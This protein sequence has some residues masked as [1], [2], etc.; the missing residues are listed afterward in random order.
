MRR[1][2]PGFG[3]AGMARA[4]PFALYI[5]FLVLREP[6]ATW[7]GPSAAAWLYAAQIAV[8]LAAL[9]IYWG[10]YVE[11]RLP[12][13]LWAR[14]RATDIALVLVVGLGVFFA[15]I[16]LDV[17]WLS[18][19]AGA[20]AASPLPGNDLDWLWIGVRIAGAALVVPVMEELFWRSFI[21]RW[22]EA[23]DFLSIDPRNVSLFAILLS[24]LAFGLE[25]SLW[26]AGLLAGLAYAWLYRRGSLWLAIA[27]HGVTNLAL[28]V[29]VVSSGQWQFW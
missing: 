19:N 4:L 29:W 8:V 13:N 24:S 16:N 6:V 2:L 10:D 1:S 3:R 28:G 26:F 12:R 18:L 22:L 14:L 25:H 7:F 11:L 17:P 27:A 21:L 5:V 9:A 23:Q 15:W 20:A